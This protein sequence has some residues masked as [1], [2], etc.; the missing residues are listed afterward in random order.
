MI[1]FEGMLV[2]PATEAGMK[3]PE[4]PEDYDPEQFPH[5][6]VYLKCQLGAS[7]P[8]PSAHWNNAKLIAGYSDAKIKTLT[9][10]ELLEDGFEVGRSK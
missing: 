4:D 9:Y 2:A 3:V 5:F 10:A 6:D 8:N 1:A 7:M